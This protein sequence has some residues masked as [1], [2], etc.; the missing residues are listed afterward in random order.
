MVAA[1]SRVA[2]PLRKASQRLAA[3][4]TLALGGPVADWRRAES[5]AAVIDAVRDSR[6]SPLLVVGGGSNLVCADVE[7]PGTVL[8]MNTRGVH[9]RSQPPTAADQLA[10]LSHHAA[11]A[12]LDE[13]RPDA[14][15]AAAPRRD[16]WLHVAAGETWDEVVA[17]CCRW[18]LAGI[19]CLSGIPGKTGATPIQNV[20]AYGQELSDCLWAVTCLD[21]ETLEV[22]T[23]S[24]AECDLGYRHSRFKAQSRDRYVVLEVTL[25]LHPHGAP[26]LGYAEIARQFETGPAPDLMAVRRAVLETRRAK[27]L[28]FDRADPNTRN[29]G[30]FFINPTVPRSHY[31]TLQHEHEGRVPG[32]AVG[33]DRVKVPAAWLIERAGFVKGERRGNVGLSTKHTLCL[34]AHDAATTNEL[35]TFAREIR[36]RVQSRFGI[37]LVPEP[38]LVG[39]EW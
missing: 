6:G 27:S 9:L 10:L 22:V 15:D 33:A 39:L 5:L 8:A 29:C 38:V 1:V 28:V 34:V 24:A 17:A 36:D 12:G 3:H 37:E 31:E 16:V 2:Q 14:L 11:N 21:R 19:E 4:T 7:F 26:N 20:G 25:R 30:S 35:L 23:F 18:E 13:S 32:F